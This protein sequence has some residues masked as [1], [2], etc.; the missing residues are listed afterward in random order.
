MRFRFENGQMGAQQVVL[1]GIPK[2]T[3]HNGGRIAFGPDGMLYAG[4]GETMACAGPEPEL[5]RRQESCG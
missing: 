3:I 2:G 4:V 1:S 5:A